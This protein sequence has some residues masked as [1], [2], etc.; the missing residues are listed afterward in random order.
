MNENIK[1]LIDKTI[2]ENSLVKINDKLYLK[3]Y[4][5]EL[6]DFYHIDYKNCSSVSEILVLI[7]AI[8]ENEEIED[9]DNLEDVANSLQEFNYYHNTNK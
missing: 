6:L 7:D 5:I 2:Y 8:L 1:N 4:Q 9:Y 3:Q